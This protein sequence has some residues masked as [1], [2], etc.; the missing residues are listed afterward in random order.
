MGGCSE[1]I[2]QPELYRV[3]Q[4]Q[5]VVAQKKVSNTGYTGCFG[6]YRVRTFSLELGLVR[7]DSG[8][9]II[10]KVLGGWGRVFSGVGRIVPR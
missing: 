8:E 10:R 1:V 3:L 7:A 5:W 2:I 6:V 4:P 9:E